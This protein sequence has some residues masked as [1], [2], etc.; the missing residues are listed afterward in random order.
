MPGYGVPETLDGA[1]PWAW[2]EAK[3]VSCRNYFVCTVRPDGR[4]H[5][6]PVWGLWHP[7]GRGASPETALF[8]FSTAVTSVKSK[9]LLADPRMAV[10]I[11]DG[12]HNVIVEGVARITPLAEVPG[13]TEGYKA[14]Y[15]EQIDEG[16]I[17]TMQPTVGF[18]F[19]EDE[20]FSTSATRYA[21]AA[22]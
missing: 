19:R 5:V 16:P 1:T 12:H 2:A 20:T 11:E 18:V 13:F 3:L 17:W 9:N 15:G 21:F 22:G 10:T 6:M 14:K 8:C 4:P 7:G